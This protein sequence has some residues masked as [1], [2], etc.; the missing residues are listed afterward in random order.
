[1]KNDECNFEREKTICVETRSFPLKLHPCKSQSSFSTFCLHCLLFIAKQSE[2]TLPHIRWHIQQLVSKR[3]FV[4]R[5]QHTTEEAERKDLVRN[6][7]S[8]DR[9]GLQYPEQEL[10]SISST[11]KTLPCGKRWCRMCWSSK[12][13]SKPFNTTK[14]LLQWQL[15]TADQ[16]T[17]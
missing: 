17:K 4:V 5:W 14:N 15:R 9:I 11:A 7:K 2:Q 16:Q 3:I 1:M 13:R 6:L 8:K 10:K 12:G